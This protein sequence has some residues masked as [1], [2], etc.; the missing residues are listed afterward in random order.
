M[1][2]LKELLMWKIRGEIPLSKYKER[3]LVFGEN[4]SMEMGC[5]LDY[6]HCFLIEIGSDVTL[7]PKV[8]I[9][10]HDASTKRSLGYAKIGRVNIGNRVFIG[11]GSIILPG[12]NI[13]DDVVIAAGSVVTKDVP[14]NSVVGGNPA[15]FLKHTEDYLIKQKENLS[16]LPVYDES[17]TVRKNIDKTKKE[18]MKKALRDKNGYVD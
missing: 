10:A 2:K 3:G 9:V 7:A 1:G 16:K 12:I 14:N 6:S 13:G 4:F 15:K 18:E 17:Y 5:T 8:S 11:L